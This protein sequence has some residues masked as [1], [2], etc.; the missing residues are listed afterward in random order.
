MAKEPKQNLIDTSAIQPKTFTP[1]SVVN[2]VILGGPYGAQNPLPGTSN[3]TVP[4]AS[5]QP[6]STGASGAEPLPDGSAASGLPWITRL[7][8][9]LGK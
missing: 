8:K 5:E 4:R 3:A 6:S 9:A 7:K 1:Q 2:P